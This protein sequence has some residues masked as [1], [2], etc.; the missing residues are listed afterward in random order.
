MKDFSDRIALPEIPE[1]AGVCF[2]EDEAGIGGVG[3]VE[4]VE[5]NPYDYPAA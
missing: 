4:V 2:I 1:G 3:I 5:R